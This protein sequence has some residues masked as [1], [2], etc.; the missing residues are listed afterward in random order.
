MILNAYFGLI[1]CGALTVTLSPLVGKA[2]TPL[3]SISFQRELKIPHS[4]PNVIGGGSRW[5]LS[6]DFSMA[7]VVA[8]GGSAAATGV[9]L[10]KKQ[11]ITTT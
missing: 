7:D 9:Y 8:F 5:D 10:M 1:G 11:W 4:L 2:I 3:T 6:H